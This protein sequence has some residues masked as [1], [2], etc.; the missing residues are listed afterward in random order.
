MS[1]NEIHD[2][3]SLYSIGWLNGSTATE[4]GLDFP[5]GAAWN[6]SFWDQRYEKRLIEGIRKDPEVAWGMSVRQIN[7]VDLPEVTAKEQFFLDSPVLVRKRLNGGT[8]EH[9]LWDSEEADQIMTDLLRKKIKESGL[10]D[11][12]QNVSVR[13]DR[14]Y[15][16]PKSKLV[17][18]KNVSHKASFCPVIVEGTEQAIQFAWCVGIGDLTGSGFGSL[19]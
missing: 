3:L 15:E 13:F 5:D 9:L 6:I 14:D 8:R 19:Q 12:H 1:W 18:I 10:S 2:E 16:N 11:E 17:T 4:N 7:E